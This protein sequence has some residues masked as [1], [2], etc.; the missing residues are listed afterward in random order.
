MSVFGRYKHALKNIAFDDSQIDSVCLPC[1]DEGVEFSEIGSINRYNA[2][3]NHYG[4]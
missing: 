2:N 1:L 4:Y 3:G